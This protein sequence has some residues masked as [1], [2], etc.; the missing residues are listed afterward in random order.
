M[1]T[2]GSILNPFIPCSANIFLDEKHMSNTYCMRKR[3]HSGEHNVVNE[4]PAAEEKKA[5]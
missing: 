3:G 2:E 5:G 4:E 1:K